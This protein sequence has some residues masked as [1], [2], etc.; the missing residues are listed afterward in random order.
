MNPHKARVLVVD[1]METLRRTMCDVLRAAGIGT[2]DEAADGVDALARFRETPYDA[3]VTDWNMPRATGLELLTAIRHAPERRDT[4]V[5]M[6]TGD[7][8]T[9]RLV[10]AL[11]AGA[12][13]FIVRPFVTP[14]LADKLL[15][16]VALLPPVTPFAPAPWLPGPWPF[17]DL[18]AP[19]PSPRSAL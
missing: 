13:G 15:R 10:T 11:E 12:N 14:A 8:T 19:R 5:L 1:D 3:I 6:V 17:T 18:L 4:P 16:I 7:V 2:I 9:R